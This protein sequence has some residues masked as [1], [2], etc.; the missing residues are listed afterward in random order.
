MTARDRELVLASRHATFGRCM[1]LLDEAESDE[2]KMDIE[3]EARRAYIIEESEH[4]IQ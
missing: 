1:E 4:D 2:A 3:D